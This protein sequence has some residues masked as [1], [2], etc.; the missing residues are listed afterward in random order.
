MQQTAEQLATAMERL[1]PL[2]ERAA[3]RQLASTARSLPTEFRVRAQPCPDVVVLD[4][5]DRERRYPTRR[6]SM[7]NLQAGQELFD[8]LKR[9][10]SLPSTD[11]LVEMARVF[12]PADVAED[13]V[14]TESLDTVLRTATEV[15]RA[16]TLS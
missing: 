5:L 12:M 3:A 11:D 7:D 4:D 9:S 16:Y 14:R 15:L 10:R 1:Q 8:R 2:E 13:F 6:P